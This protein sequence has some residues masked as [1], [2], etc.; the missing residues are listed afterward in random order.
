[1]S[2]Q[3]L[4][5]AFHN[6]RNRIPSEMRE[7]IKVSAL[8]GVQMIENAAPHHIVGGH[9]ADIPEF[10]TQAWIDKNAPKA[11]LEYVAAP[12]GEEEFDVDGRRAVALGE[13]SH[14]NSTKD[15]GPF[16]LESGKNDGRLEIRDNESAL[17]TAEQEALNR[18][19]MQ[20]PFTQAELD[21]KCRDWIA[22][23]PASMHA[24]V[25]ADY[26]TLVQLA[27]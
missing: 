5:K 1:M 21:S 11:G 9:L 4:L 17:S 7:T 18:Y 20:F 6:Y 13:N 24:Q 8:E 19:H 23:L 3:K 22:T 25:R 15:V 2:D 14:N 16:T 27:S 26:K 10:P 12:E